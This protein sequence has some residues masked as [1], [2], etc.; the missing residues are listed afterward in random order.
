MHI[1]L[2]GERVL[3]VEDEGD[4]APP[5]IDGRFGARPSCPERTTLKPSDHPAGGTELPR[6][7]LPRSRGRNWSFRVG[8]NAREG[9]V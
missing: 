6:R 1:D 5:T 2:T 8:F 9:L 4:V 3:R 7:R